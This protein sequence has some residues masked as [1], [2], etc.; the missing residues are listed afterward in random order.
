MR[1][2][3][4]IMI[5]PILFMLTCTTAFA[6]Y[7]PTPPPPASTYDAYGHMDLARENNVFLQQVG[8][9]NQALLYLLAL[10]ILG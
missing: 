2:K 1:I 6:D 9:K 4:D 7:E 10:F 5:L 3:E 8:Q